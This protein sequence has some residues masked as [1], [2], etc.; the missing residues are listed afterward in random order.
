M[1]ED[2]SII[3]TPPRGTNHKYYCSYCNTR[4]VALSGEANKGGYICTKC[5]IEYW[6]EQQPVK[7]ASHF[8]MPGPDTDSQ[9]NIIRDQKIPI[10][11]IEDVHTELSSTS[12][13]QQKLPE[14]Y[15][16]LQ[17]AGYLWVSYE[18]R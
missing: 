13:K 18:E 17:K 10:A 2:N 5:T 7:K 4:L 15:R 14:S 11:M 16:A 8:R 9:G 3:I 1:N 6:P 12:Y